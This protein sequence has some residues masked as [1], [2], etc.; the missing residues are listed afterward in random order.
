MTSYKRRKQ[1][2]K[3]WKMGGWL[4]LSLVVVTVLY[5]GQV[6]M[7]ATSGMATRRQALELEKLFTHNRELELAARALETLPNLSETSQRLQF[8]KL[9]NVK[10]LSSN[11]GGQVVARR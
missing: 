3:S 5:L 2:L 10:Y 11:N 1:K 9:Q 6:N 7:I 8:I 4:G